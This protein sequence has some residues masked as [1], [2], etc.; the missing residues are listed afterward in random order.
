MYNHLTFIYFLDILQIF[1]LLN[2]NYEN[3]RCKNL[4]SI[5][6]SREKKR[7]DNTI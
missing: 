5:F 2:V 6:V 7:D 1:T 4:F 3:R